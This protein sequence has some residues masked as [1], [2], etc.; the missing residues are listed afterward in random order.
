MVLSVN[1]GLISIGDQT[2]S[3]AGVA[4]LVTMGA[5]AGLYTDQALRR[6]KLLLGMSAG[7]RA[8][9]PAD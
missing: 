9:P 6:L 3:T 7:N 2:T 4:V 8:K 5:L 1:T